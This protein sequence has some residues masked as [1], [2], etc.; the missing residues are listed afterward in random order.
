MADL[1]FSLVP[2]INMYTNGFYN[3]LYPSGLLNY[4]NLFMFYHEYIPS[5][6]LDSDQVGSTPLSIITASIT[7][8][9]R[10]GGL[11]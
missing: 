7:F 9:T 4:D 2:F 5:C 10:P 8:S 3:T 6:F 1:Y 11:A